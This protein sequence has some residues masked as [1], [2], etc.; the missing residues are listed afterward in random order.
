MKTRERENKNKRLH[1]VEKCN[2]R[3]EQSRMYPA[4]TNVQPVKKNEN[5]N[6]FAN[7]FASSNGLFYL[8]V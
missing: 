8:K 6:Q 2:R 4:G 7:Q 1:S 3:M 5:S